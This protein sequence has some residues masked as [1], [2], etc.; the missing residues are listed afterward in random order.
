MKNKN[1][2]LL[3]VN[4]SFGKNPVLKNLN[5]EIKE[6]EFLVLL[7]P[8]GCGKTT[9]LRCV[10]GL[11][12][13]DSGKIFIGEKDVTDLPPSKRNISMVFQNYA[14]F[15]HMNV[16]DNIAFGLKM[17]KFKKDFI[18]KKVKEVSELLKIEDLLERYPSQLSGGQRQRVAVARALAVEPDVLLMDE[19]LSN[20][21]ALLRSEMRSELKRIHREQGSTTLYVTHDQIEALTLGDRIAVMFDG[22]IHQIGSP[23]EIYEYPENLEVGRFIGTPPMN[24][25]KCV[26]E[27]NKI[28]AGNQNFNPGERILNLVKQKGLKE[29]YIGIRAEN[30]EIVGEKRDDTLKGKILVKENLGFNEILKVKLENFFIKILTPPS[31]DLKSD[32]EIFFRFKEEKIRVYDGGGRLVV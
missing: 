2:K 19:P 9:T 26:F 5:L 25:I 6:G 15:P 32:D 14:V 17:K 3:N 27:N 31:P 28:Y 24:F 12:K 30:I 13:V 8:S 23:H 29:F 20:L 11:E 18:D 21:D 4:K 7:G 22:I 10:A 16:Y 1:V